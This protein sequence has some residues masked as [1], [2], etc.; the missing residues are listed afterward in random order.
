[1]TDASR[2]YHSYTTKKLFLICKVLVH[3]IFSNL[4]KTF[5][6]MYIHLQHIHH[7]TLNKLK[8]GN[9]EF[10]NGKSECGGPLDPAAS[11]VSAFLRRYFSLCFLFFFIPFFL[12][13]CCMSCFFSFPL[14]LRTFINLRLRI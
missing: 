2:W 12:S 1:M 4:H 13:H 3:L 10:R 9:T 7:Y 8:K 11:A 6:S 14:T 5:S